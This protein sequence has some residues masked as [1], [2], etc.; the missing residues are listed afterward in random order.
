MLILKWRQRYLER[1]E[2][3]S[4]ELYPLSEERKGNRDAR[5]QNLCGSNEFKNGQSEAVQSN[6]TGLWVTEFFTCFI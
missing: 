3:I 2:G 6:I 5:C 4:T 1:F